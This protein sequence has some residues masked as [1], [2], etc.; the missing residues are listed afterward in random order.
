MERESGEKGT[1]SEP[2]TV[3][4]EKDIME[5]SKRAFGNTS[6][7]LP[8]DLYTLKN[9]KGVEMEVTNYGG[10]VV[11][12]RV[13][14][15]DGNL[16]D[17]VLGHDSLEAYQTESPYFGALVGRYGN[18]IAKGKFTLGGIEY[19]CAQN[20]GENHLHGGLVG[21]DKKVW[22]TTE[23]KGAEHVAL[24]M[25][26]ISPDGDEGYPGELSV[27]VV[28]TLNNNNEFQID[29]SATTDKTTVV[30]LTHH[31]YFNLSGNKKLS[32]VLDG[33]LMIKGDHYTEVDEGLIPTGKLL[34]VEGTVMDFNEFCSIRQK[35][36]NHEPELLIGGGFD[37]NWALNNPEG[38]LT[39]VAR[40]VEPESGRALELYTTAPGMQ[41]YTGNSLGGVVG[42]GGLVYENYTGFCMETQHFPDSPNHFNFPSTVLHP[43]ETYKHTTVHRFLVES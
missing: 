16:D 31:S 2:R 21:F 40:M 42:K 22:K 7:G 34:P 23:E 3:S 19:Y 30:N 39:Y 26:L 10:I 28:Y 35:I 36:E 27:T 32:N 41:F 38:N 18:R 17:V 14:D 43:D 11:A 24:V 37:H 6:E 33:H 13:P 8:T 20:Q 12:L 29:Y 9:D 15:R 5:I 25:T 1:H 4:I